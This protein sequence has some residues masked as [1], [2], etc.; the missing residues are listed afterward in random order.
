MLVTSRFLIIEVG[1]VAYLV[2]ICFANAKNLHLKQR[3][4]SGS[5]RDILRQLFNWIIGGFAFCTSYEIQLNNTVFFYFA[6]AKNLH[7]E[8]RGG[9]GAGNSRDILRQQFY[10]I[11]GFAFCISYEIQFNNTACLVFCKSQEPSYEAE[12]WIL[13]KLNRHQ[14]VGLGQ[15]PPPP[16]WEFSLHNPVFFLT[17]S[18]RQ[19]FH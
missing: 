7:M 4:G 2:F 10:W 9:G 17:T 16:V 6:K 14:E 13:D 1:S 8:Q 18:L 3:D 19:Q 15:T 12:R 5:S 11:G